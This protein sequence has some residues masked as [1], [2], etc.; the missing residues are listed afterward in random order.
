MT[1][2]AMTTTEAPEDKGKRNEAL[3]KAIGFD[4]LAPEQ[5]ALGL[6]IAKR[7][8]LD[9]LLKHLVIIEGRVYITR[10]GLLHVAHRSKKL[11]GIEVT[12]PVIRDGFWRS[13]CSVYRKDMSRPFTRNG[14][15]IFSLF[16]R[17]FSCPML[18][19]TS[20]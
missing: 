18:A 12:E 5:R 17:S 20:V 9:L 7:Y 2:Q 15:K 11:D 14:S 13:T 6:N 16:S 1:D 10:D 4:K 19:Q 3:M 8:E